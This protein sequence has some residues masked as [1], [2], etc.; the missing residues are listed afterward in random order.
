MEG[1]RRECGK[2]GKW[3]VEEG[4]VERRESGGLLPVSYVSAIMH[5][6]HMHKT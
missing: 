6:I 1:R 5:N 4:K 3:R 2:K